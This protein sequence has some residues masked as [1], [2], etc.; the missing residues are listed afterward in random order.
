VKGASSLGESSQQ[1]HCCPLLEASWEKMAWRPGLD[2]RPLK[3][4]W[5]SGSHGR[6]RPLNLFCFSVVL[7]WGLSPFRNMAGKRDLYLYVPFLNRLSS[8]NLLT[9]K[10]QKAVHWENTSEP[11]F[12]ICLRWVYWHLLPL[13][14][15]VVPETICSSWVEGPGEDG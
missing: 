8:T 1:I 2:T 6:S 15:L 14:K 9:F 13:W 3:S 4:R 7:G 12:F 10:V 5:I 11:A